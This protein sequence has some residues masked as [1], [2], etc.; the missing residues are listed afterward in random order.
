MPKIITVNGEINPDELGFTLSHEHIFTDIRFYWRGETEDVTLNKLF[1]QPIS[2]ETHAEAKYYPWHFKDN[3]V[4]DDVEERIEEVGNFV[5][6]GGNSIVDVTPTNT[7]GRNPVQ[8]RYVSRATG[9]NIVMSS[10]LYAAAAC[11]EE[12]NKWSAEDVADYIENEFLNGVGD[13]GIKPGVIKIAINYMENN[14][15]IKHLRG[16]GQAQKRIGAALYVH[17]V[18]WEKHDL[19]IL[20]ILEK[21]GADPHKVVFCHQD[22]TGHF[23]EYHDAVAKRGAFI[24]IDT[25]GCESVAKWDEDL[26]F[27]SDQQKIDI[28]KKQLELGNLEH[29]LISG[30]LCLKIFFKR[31]GGWGY[32]HIPKHIVPRM[33]KNGISNDAIRTITIENPKRLLSF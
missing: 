1:R 3:L 4:I 12:Q 22:F 21:E 26:W 29:L 2:L 17:P 30:D 24:E 23:P 7:I 19:D 5:K 20:D 6:Y 15:E 25:F 9:A 14:I 28:V 11:T 32:E 27:L 10:G 31:Y 18:I 33:R 13:T 16:A 8:L